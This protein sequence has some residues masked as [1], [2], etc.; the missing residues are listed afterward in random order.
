M[1]LKKLLDEMPYQWRVQSFSKNKPNCSCVAYIDARDVMKRLDEIVGAENWQDDYRV[2]HDQ[3][4]AGIGVRT[5]E[6]W[7][8]KW[9][10]GTESQTEKEKGI[11]S[12]SFKRAAVKWGI[13]RFLY[14][15]DVVY[16]PTNGIKGDADTATHKRYPSPI[17][18]QGKTVYDITAHVN[19]LKGRPTQTP[20]PKTF[21]NEVMEIQKATNEDE[22]KQ[23]WAGLSAEAKASKEC[24]EAGT[25]VK[26]TFK[27]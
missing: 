3:L 1:E 2:V 24:V 19:G 21:D 4:F 12:D 25:K 10:T 22:L 14:D 9:D 11:V 27:K 16:L 7:V 20:K 26:A 15:L 23:I 6:G 17:D 8:W 5:K 13:G 18:A